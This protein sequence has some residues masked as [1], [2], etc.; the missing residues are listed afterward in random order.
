MP[1]WP[2]LERTYVLSADEVDDGC[3][4]AWGVIVGYLVTLGLPQAISQER[5]QNTPI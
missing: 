5:N 1:A 2:V 4:E 3:K